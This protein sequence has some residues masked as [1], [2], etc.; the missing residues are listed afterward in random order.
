[1]IEDINNDVFV[2]IQTDLLVIGDSI[3][4][5]RHHASNG[6]Y[7]ISRRKPTTLVVG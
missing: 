4:T 3:I 1:M 2:R 6:N 5:D 7:T